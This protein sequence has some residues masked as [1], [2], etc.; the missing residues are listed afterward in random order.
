[1][2]PGERARLG[3]VRRRVVARDH[4]YP[5]RRSRRLRPEAD[6]ERLRALDEQ[7]PHDHA[8]AAEQGSDRERG[9]ESDARRADGV[10]S[11]CHGSATDDN[12]PKPPAGLGY[13]WSQVSGPGTVQFVDA[14]SAATDASFSAPGTYVVQ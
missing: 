9:V 4:R 13:S 6:G 11:R 8:H 12:L 2:D 5:Q 3:D 10:G 7:H 14:S 1:M